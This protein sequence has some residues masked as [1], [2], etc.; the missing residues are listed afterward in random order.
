MSTT[1]KTTSQLT[2]TYKQQRSYAWRNEQAFHLSLDDYL[3]VLAEGPECDC[4]KPAT[5]LR[6][7]DYLRPYR[8]D[9][10][11]PSCGSCS[12]VKARHGKSIPYCKHCGDINCEV[13]PEMLKTF[14]GDRKALYFFARLAALPKTR[15]TGDPA[16]R[17]CKSC[18]RLTCE[19]CVPLAK[20]LFHGDTASLRLHLRTINRR[21]RGAEKDKARPSEPVKLIWTDY[22]KL[23]SEL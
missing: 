7:R 20:A 21:Q 6:K 18:L 14:D 4:G 10:M 8:K 9:N 11:V 12:R 3:E 22:S 5:G 17:C 16:D 1:T 2:R 15:L 19:Q 13:C 23:F